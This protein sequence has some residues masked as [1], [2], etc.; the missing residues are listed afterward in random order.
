MISLPAVARRGDAA[1]R[2]L[3]SRIARRAGWTPAVLAHPG[4]GSGGR[5][6]VLG[7]VLLAPA[8]VHPEDRRAVPGWQRFL[9]LESPGAEVTVEVAGRRTVVRSDDDGLIDVTLV[10]PDGLPD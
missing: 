5:L 4:Y 3:A 1:L 7:R 2:D 10:F 8:G 9:T 6:R